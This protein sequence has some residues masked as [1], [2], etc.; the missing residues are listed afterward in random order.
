[1][2]KFK[3]AVLSFLVILLLLIALVCCEFFG[4]FGRS[5]TVEIK[6]GESIGHV[7]AKLK[8]QGAIKS[9]A[10]FR[11][12][13]GRENIVMLPG[14]MDVSAGS[15]YDDIL[16]CFAE[17]K[18]SDTVK[19]T[20][21]EACEVKDIVDELEAEG[22]IERSKFYE[23]SREYDFGYDFLEKAPKADNRLEG[24][25]FPDTYYFSKSQDDEISIIKKMLA[26]F[27]EIYEPIKHLESVTGRNT[28]EIVTLASIAQ[29]EAATEEDLKIVAG[30]LE[31]R[32][33]NKEYGYLQACV[34]IQYV[35]PRKKP[36]LTFED[37]KV[38]S[39]YNTYKY[40]GLPPGPIACPGELAIRAALEPAKTNYYYFVSDSDNINHFSETYSQHLKYIKEYN[41]Q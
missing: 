3:I 12:Y 29:R 30:I 8:E 23:V 4:A 1:M 19:I 39:L 34:S 25:L 22:L 7:A 15:S 33:R 27:A 35:L 6:N 11:F 14:I 5:A 32:L 13:A 21:M 2:K 31:N 20:F 18:A 38:D 17:L 10:L 26:R 24:F 16:A 28:Y 37:T 40:P 9:A 41:V 36:V